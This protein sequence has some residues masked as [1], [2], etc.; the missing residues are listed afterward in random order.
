MPRHTQSPR[1]H[2][3]W[4]VEVANWAT[5]FRTFGSAEIT[6]SAPSWVLLAEFNTDEHDLGAG[7]QISSATA[8]LDAGGHC[9][10]K[11]ERQHSRGTQVEYYSLPPGGEI[12]VSAVY[13]TRI[14]AGLDTN[15]RGA[16]G[17]ARLN[18]LLL[19]K[20]H[21]FIPCYTE[22]KYLT[23]GTVLLPGGWQDLP[24][25]T[26]G[27]NPPQN[28]YNISVSSN[29]GEYQLIDWVT[30]LVVATGL[31]TPALQVRLTHNTD[32]RFQVR[33]PLGMDGALNPTFISA[34]W[35]Q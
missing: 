23:D 31:I 28:R 24:S 33:Q 35:T 11:L 27:R 30:G 17:T 19:A 14:Y 16:L 9:I 25:L 26:F 2:W 18:W 21:G 12:V 3:G 7:I 20:Y 32:L 8:A 15:T 13:P 34:I 10:I 5:N 1:N 29:R 6:L 4:A 22:N